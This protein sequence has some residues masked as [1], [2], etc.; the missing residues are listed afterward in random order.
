MGFNYESK[1]EVTVRCARSGAP[2]G[3]EGVESPGGELRFD[4]KVARDGAGVGPRAAIRASCSTPRASS[5]DAVDTRSVE[6]GVSGAR[7]AEASG[8]SGGGSGARETSSEGT[9]WTTTTTTGAT[10][11]GRAGG[12]RRGRAAKVRVHSG[13]RD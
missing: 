4:V 12:R 2:D 11:P 5:S 13:H 10:R 1:V 8:S 3:D 6:C 9:G 7:G